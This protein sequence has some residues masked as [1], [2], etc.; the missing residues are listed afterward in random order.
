[1]SSNSERHINGNRDCG[2]LRT[3]FA[4][5]LENNNLTQ[6]PVRSILRQAG[7]VLNVRGKQFHNLVDINV[8]DDEE[9]S[10][11]PPRFSGRPSS[12]SL[13]RAFG[14]EEPRK[15]GQTLMDFFDDRWLEFYATNGNEKSQKGCPSVSV[16]DSRKGQNL[17]PVLSKPVSELRRPWFAVYCDEMYDPP[18]PCKPDNECSSPLDPDPSRFSCGF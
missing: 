2:N 3:T 17:Q 4:K 16:K 11:S 18:D 8:S 13:K 15:S 9:E 12:V 1:M 10:V 6:E 7:K 14:I 5:N